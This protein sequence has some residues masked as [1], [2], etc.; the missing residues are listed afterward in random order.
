MDYIH[1]AKNMQARRRELR[2]N[3][4]LQEIILWKYLRKKKLGYL[5]YR[6][7][8]IG[9]YVVDFYCP[10]AKLIIELDGQQHQELENKKYDSERTVFFETLGFRVIRFWNSEIDNE[11]NSVLFTIQKNL[12]EYFSPPLM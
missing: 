1:N 7:H 4:T 8:S 5:F 10:Q 3:A 2:K 6:Q 11:I 12:S 9:P